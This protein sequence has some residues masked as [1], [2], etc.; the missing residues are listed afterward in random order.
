MYGGICRVVEPESRKMDLPG[1]RNSTASRAMACFCGTFSDSRLEMESTSVREM[2]FT[3]R[4]P[5]CTRMTSP[6]RSK[7]SISRR[8]VISDTSG[9]SRVSSLSDTKGFDSSIFLISS[10]LCD[11]KGHS[12]LLCYIL[13]LFYIIDVNLSTIFCYKM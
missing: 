5:P 3:E 11:F 10:R 9:N 1:S 12:P 2:N 7:N 4:A 6:S 8:M 13:N